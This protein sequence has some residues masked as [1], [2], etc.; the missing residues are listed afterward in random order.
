MSYFIYRIT[1]H[2][3]QHSYFGYIEF[4]EMFHQD[5]IF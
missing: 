5:N 3:A 2:L 1:A 4:Q